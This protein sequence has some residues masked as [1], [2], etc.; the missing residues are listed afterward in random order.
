MK[1]KLQDEKDKNDQLEKD[2]KELEDDSGKEVY[3]R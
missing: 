3:L 1:K 2:K